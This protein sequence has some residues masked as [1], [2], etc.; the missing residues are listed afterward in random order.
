MVRQV[1]RFWARERPLLV[2]ALLVLAGT[3]VGLW[4]AAA[5]PPP[6]AEASADLA[7][8]CRYDAEAAEVVVPVR[9]DARATEPSQLEL[10]AGVATED[11]TPTGYTAS[12]TLEIDGTPDAEQTAE[13]VQVRVTLPEPVWERGGQD[14]WVRVA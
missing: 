10:T 11:G 13:V 6:P 1:R 5:A 2:V 4:R 8:A 14:C 12:R 7:G 3:T 9:V